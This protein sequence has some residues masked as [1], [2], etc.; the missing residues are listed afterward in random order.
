[1]KKPCSAGALFT[2]LLFLFLPSV[3]ISQNNVR[4]TTF[5]PRVGQ[6]GKDVIWVP[7]PFELVRKMLEVADVGPND[8]V[9]DLGS[10]DGRTVISAARL[11]ARALGIEYN[12]EMVQLS[13]KHA[14]EAGVSGKASFIQADLFE[15]DLSEATVITMFLLPEINL[16]L[17]PRLLDL[18]PGTR[19]VSNTFNM[20]NWEPDF[21]VTADTTWS[22]WYTALLWIVP[23]KIGGSYKF[24][25]GE[26]NIEQEF[27]LFFG[28]YT[29]GSEITLINEGRINGYGI[30]FVLNGEKYSGEM[31][32]NGNLSGTVT[33]KNQKRDWLAVRNKSPK[34]H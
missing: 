31:S 34:V 22:N 14:E 30:T 26:L 10:G 33:S 24:A 18:R 9:I 6:E 28:S 29:K 5:V 4:D 13:R 17:R 7:T 16:K 19:I 27:Q 15:Y 3:L 32:A 23:A 2:V 12:P 11:G 8:Y 20:G 21:E 1:M 25:E